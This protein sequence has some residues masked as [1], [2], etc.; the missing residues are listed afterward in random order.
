M[1]QIFPVCFI[2]Y[3]LARG[4]E[5]YLSCY[6]DAWRGAHGS[7][8]GFNET[9]CSLAA[10]DRLKR[11]PGSLLEERRAGWIA[12]CYVAEELRG[13]GIG[14]AIIARAEERYA[15]QGRRFLRLSVAPGNPAL[16]FYEKLGFRRAGAEPGALEDL[17]IMEK[18][19]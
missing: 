8:A 14:R 9:A 11:D 7:L 12:F 15:A 6:R 3:D 10:A 17:Y 2:P 16:A 4:M 19:L 13:R 5:R 18:E 1:S